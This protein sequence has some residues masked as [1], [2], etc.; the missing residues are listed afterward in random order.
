MANNTNKKTQNPIVGNSELAQKIRTFAWPKTTLGSISEWPQSLLT[1]VN[2]LLQSPVPMVMLWGEEGIMLYNDAYSIFAGR[3]HPSLLG[4][5]VIEGWPEVADFN[6]NVMKKGLHGKTLSYNDQ[7]LT[8]YRNN[9]PEKV[10]MDL[11]YSPIMN[12]LGNPAGV[13]AIVVETTQR[14]RAEKRQKQAEKDLQ[15]EKDR[16]LTIFTQAPAAIAVV[17]G[18][19]HTFVMANPLYQ[20]LIGKTEKQLLGKPGRKALPE[21]VAQGIWKEFDTILKTGKPFIGKEFPARLNRLQHGKSNLGYFNFVAEALRDSQGNIFRIL[22]HAVEVTQQVEARKKLHEANNTLETIIKS[23]P[24]A[25][26]VLD[27][28][29]NITVW[30]KVAEEL[31]GWK[32]AEVKGKPLPF[33][34]NDRQKEHKELIESLVKGSS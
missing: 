7:T 2:I 27:Q 3:R 9:T 31:F 29:G 6:K 34:P 16:L 32:E 28:K 8:L 14:V 17:E 22:I 10:T 20:K 25:V 21:L 30:N 23:S 33:I 15:F 11:N 19:E 4:S 26:Y 1:T 18:K 13:L 12:E 5:K 24:L